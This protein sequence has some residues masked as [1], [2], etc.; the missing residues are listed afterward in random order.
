VSQQSK[1][2]KFEGFLLAN[3]M[4]DEGIDKVEKAVL[5]WVAAFKLSTR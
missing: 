5:G 4:F 2:G 3:I 1:S